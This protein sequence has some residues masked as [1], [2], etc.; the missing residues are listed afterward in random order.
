MLCSFQMYSKVIQSH[1]YMYLISFKF[2][3]HV[4]YY[5][6]LSRVPYTI[7][8]VLVGCL[9]LLLKKLLW[10]MKNTTKS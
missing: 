8:Q 7:Q 6:I 5:R 4:G 2:F 9:F 1:I 3:S 10:F